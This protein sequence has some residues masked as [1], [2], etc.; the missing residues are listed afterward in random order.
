MSRR[1]AKRA[2]V[3][4]EP[5]SELPAASS[6]HES[7]AD[8]EAWLKTVAG[9]A[10]GI[11]VPRCGSKSPAAICVSAVLGDPLGRVTVL[12]GRDN[13]P[14]SL[15][16]ANGG[17]VA[18]FL[19]G[20][21]IQGRREA[22]TEYSGPHVTCVV[23]KPDGSGYLATSILDTNLFELNRDGTIKRVIGK[24]YGHGEL[25]FYIPTQVFIA[26][27]GFVFVAEAG[28]GRIQIL[29]PTYKF[30]AFLDIRTLIGQKHAAP[31]GVVVTDTTIFVSVSSW[32][33]P[34]HS[35]HCVLI[36]DRATG[37][38]RSQFGGM[39]MRH[40]RGMCLLPKSGLLAVT[41]F[42]SR[43]IQ[44]YTPS[45]EFVRETSVSDDTPPFFVSSTCNGE[46]IVV[47]GV[48]DTPGVISVFNE[49]LELTKSWDV[50]PDLCAA[51]YDP[52][53]AKVVVVSKTVFESY[54]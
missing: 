1:E 42:Q 49:S 53:T 52:A 54:V 39:T 18:Q 16:S 4:P 21:P 15:G 44:L 27:D 2:R 29:T 3:E 31:R 33:A 23:P 7:G 40:P 43:C 37:T 25:K 34:L 8:R 20:G 45:G 13:L 22:Q 48:Y 32:Q 14:W 10:A 46:L 26:A 11:A 38:L 50:G 5:E 9:V 41:Q 30:H 6:A 35:Q 51:V 12:G 17:K 28:N 36:I 24:G 19:N 47:P